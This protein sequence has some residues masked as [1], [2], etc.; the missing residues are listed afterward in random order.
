LFI[1]IDL[2]TSSVKSILIDS[3]DTVI[4][5]ASAPLEV[6]RPHPT[7]SEQAPADWWTAT[8]KTLDE[9][10]AKF[11]KEMAADQGIGL[12]GQ[13]HGATILDENGNPLRPCILWNDGRSEQEC[14]EIAKQFPE[15]SKLTGN[16]AMPGFT[17]PKLL[18]VRRH[19]P[20]IFKQVAFV[21]LPKAY[22]RYLLSGEMVED[23]SD[24]SGTL[25][26]DVGKRDWSEELL[27]AMHMSRKQMPKL[28]EG[29]AISAT[30]KPE[31]AQRWGMTKP[32]VIAGGGGDNAAGAA[33][34]GVIKPGDA[35]LSLGTS[36]VLFLVT[37]KFLP[38][39]AKAVHAF[40]H[41]LPGVWHQMS[42]MLS[43]ASCV[44]WAVKLTG[45]KD[46]AELLSKVEK[47]ASLG[48]PE[49]FLPYLSGERTPHND[50][51]ARGVLFGL[52]HDSDAAAIGQ[53]VL[54]GVAFA[55]AD[56]LDA[57]IEAGATI[58]KIS[59]IGGGARS[60]WWGGVLAAAL[61]RPLVYRDGSEV[62]PA[63]GAARLARIAKTKERAED[64]CR[65]PPVRA[66]VEP[67]A[68]DIE[69]LAPKRA[70]FSKIY[71]DLRPRFRGE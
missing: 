36:G 15:I 54:E 38:N 1:G 7:W 24:A 29:S 68:R 28:V 14:I 51:A 35:F 44:D 71:Q 6:S 48:G 42:V 13:Q 34:I 20:E 17:G 70:Q 45:M 30:L 16:P 65:P 31:L 50:P 69:Q 26:L 49:I 60:M 22:L 47:R 10:K 8:V 43:A 40:C 37:P 61:K 67:N 52:N 23:M 32:P 41:C 27:T 18:W 55:F 59:V 57:L 2:G 5:T 21:L 12:S 58:D 62:G 63:F 56:G 11:P 66:T 39:S 3:N 25:W 64:V 9:I 46:A 33:G 53:A 19:E 4:A